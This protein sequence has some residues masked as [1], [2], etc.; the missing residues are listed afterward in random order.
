VEHHIGYQFGGLRKITPQRR[1][2]NGG[3]LLG[4]KGVQLTAEIFEARI[5]VERTAM[6]GT[7]E[8]R[9]LSQ[10]GDAVFPR[11]FVATAGV[12]RQRT[13]RN[14]RAHPFQNAPNTVRQ[15]KYEKFLIPQFFIYRFSQLLIM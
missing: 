1:G 15:R 4:G 8:Y 10:M 7:F 12:N 6:L 3:I 5:Y 13:V 11:E 2:V 9:V 14:R